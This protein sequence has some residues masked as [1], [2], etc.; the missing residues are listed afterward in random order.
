MPDSRTARRSGGVGTIGGSSAGRRGEA[1]G[2]PLERS[3]KMRLGGVRGAGQRAGVWRGAGLPLTTTSA[4]SRAN[5]RSSAS[6]APDGPERTS[7]T[8]PGAPVA[9]C[10]SSSSSARSICGKR[11]PSRAAAQPR[12]GSSPPQ[13][14][15]SSSATTVPGTG[16]APRLCAAHQCTTAGTPQRAAA[17]GGG[18]RPMTLTRLCRLQDLTSDSLDRCP[19]DGPASRG[20]VD[21]DPLVE[22]PTVPDLAVSGI[23]RA[24]V[25]SRRAC[26]SS[27]ARNS[28]T[29]AECL[30]CRGARCRTLSS[31]RG[32]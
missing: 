28:G 2:D 17:D 22:L 19:S 11:A 5:A 13:R 23:R 15:W 1:R 9:A 25:Q 18:V 16:S 14:R 3:A 26:R 29:R 6:V 7:A 4:P 20:L 8:T 12:S 30:R 32:R 21:A 24:R 31:G 10:D 27:R